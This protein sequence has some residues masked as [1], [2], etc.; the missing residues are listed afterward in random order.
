MAS[1]VENFLKSDFFRNLFEEFCKK[2]VSEF[3][4]EIEPKENLRVSPKNSEVVIVL[5]YGPKSHAIF[6]D[7]GDTNRSFKDDYLMKQNWIKSN[8]KLAFG[9]GWV[10]MQKDKLEDV[11]KAL[12]DM[13]VVFREVE[14][15]DYEKEVRNSK[16]HS[17][18]PLK[19]LVEEK[20]KKK[21]KAVKNKWGNNEEPAS[22]FVF[23]KLPVGNNNKNIAVAV[24]LQDPDA[25]TTLRGLLSILPFNEELKKECKIKGW[26]YLTE[27]M[28]G[29]IFTQNQK[30]AEQL[31]KMRKCELDEGYYVMLCATC[32]HDKTNKQKCLSVPFKFR[33]E[34]QWG[35]YDGT[36]FDDLYEEF[37][38]WL[39]NN[40]HEGWYIDD[41]LETEKDITPAE[42]RNP[43][44]VPVI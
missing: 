26:R 25:D 12:G 28:I 14:R 22:G 2:C 6:G 32:E 18:E 17:S 19:E 8:R 15:M 24:G 44:I 3:R 33:D 23:I 27:K 31:D 21:F 10:V 40:G 13:N 38:D 1:S 20:S 36:G 35:I 5:N 34:E 4:T 9:F 39:Q 43:V 7:F 30:L 42:A 16:S 37:N 11:K 29:T 41:I